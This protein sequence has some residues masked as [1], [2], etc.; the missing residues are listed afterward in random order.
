MVKVTARREIATETSVQSRYYISSPG[1][2]RHCFRPPA[3]THRKQPALVARKSVKTMAPRI[4]LSCAR[5][6]SLK[7]DYP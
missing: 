2:A 5:L 6:P 1:Q 4:W 3:A 7:G